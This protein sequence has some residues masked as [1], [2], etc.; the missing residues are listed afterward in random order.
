MNDLIHHTN[1][2]ATH[3]NELEALT[4]YIIHLKVNGVEDISS[5]VGIARNLTKIFNK[6]FEVS[7]VD[8]ESIT[9]FFGVNVFPTK[10]TIEILAERF[11]ENRDYGLEDLIAITEHSNWI[12]EIDSK[13]LNDKNLNAT[14]EEIIAIILHE[15]YN[16]VFGVR[17]LIRL[18]NAFIDKKE[19]MN[20][21][22][23]TIARHNESI[24]SNIFTMPVAYVYTVK[25]FSIR[26]F[27]SDLPADKAVIEFGY[28]KYLERIVGKMI[29]AYG[30]SGSDI[31]RT[32]KD[33]ED[34]VGGVFN[35]IINNLNTRYIKQQQLIIAIRSEVKK[36]RSLVMR[37]ILTSIIPQ[38]IMVNHLHDNELDYYERTIMEE[39]WNKI[40]DT[41]TTEGLLSIFD[42]DK[43]VKTVKAEDVDYIRL[44]VD[45]IKTHDDRMYVLDLIYDQLDLIEASEDL[46][47][48]G[49]S[50]LVKMKPAD[51]K[52]AKAELNKLR[53]Q[54][55]SM[56][57]DERGSSI[58][59]K[60]PQG[61]EG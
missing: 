44:N 4:Q 10:D 58:I 23:K 55:L 42:R 2:Y 15:I 49:K 17:P 40:L 43:K 13:L 61:Y 31:N 6:S 53:L 32:E 34:E 46:I 60:Y 5:C 48:H 18:R 33:C 27:E 14:V 29:S 37:D 28:G 54:V 47:A 30:I 57:V 8:T 12:I 22:F 50:N 51:I 20:L 26:I 39:R 36:T 41:Y 3:M 56:K 24:F 52:E 7:I 11:A 59:I 25:N 1:K 9:E 35:W 38:A 21:R 19:I 16:S 45:R